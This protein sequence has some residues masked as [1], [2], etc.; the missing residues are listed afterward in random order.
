MLLLAYTEE[1]HEIYSSPK[2]GLVPKWEKTDQTQG[3]RSYEVEIGFVV[4]LLDYMDVS[5]SHTGIVVTNIQIWAWNYK[6][7]AKLLGMHID[8][9]ANSNV[10]FGA[11]FLIDPLLWNYTGLKEMT[12]HVVNH[13][14]TMNLHGTRNR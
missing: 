9:E 12:R 14:L 11:D 2:N 8:L 1:H 3:I 5:Y 7:L 10:N 6:L 13:Y 4:V